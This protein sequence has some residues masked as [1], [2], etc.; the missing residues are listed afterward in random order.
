MKRLKQIGQE[1]IRPE[2]LAR[3]PTSPMLFERGM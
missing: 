3:L 1:S 2:P